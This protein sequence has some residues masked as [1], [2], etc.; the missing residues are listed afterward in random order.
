[1][2]QI[3]DVTL[4]CTRLAWVRVQ[5]SLLGLGLGI[6]DRLGRVFFGLRF[7]PLRIERKI[8]LAFRAY[9]LEG[10]DTRTAV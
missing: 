7:S 2:F 9:I 10:I 1:M 6:R 3:V 4:R 8:R 5:P